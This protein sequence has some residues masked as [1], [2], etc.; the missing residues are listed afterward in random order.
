[1]RVTGT[2]SLFSSKEGCGKSGATGWQVVS[3]KGHRLHD[4]PIWLFSDLRERSS[5]E[6]GLSGQIPLQP[7]MPTGP[8]AGCP[9]PPNQRWLEPLP[10]I[11]CRRLEATSSKHTSKV[12]TGHPQRAPSSGAASPKPLRLQIPKLGPLPLTCQDKCSAW[13]WWG[14]IS[15]WPQATDLRALLPGRPQPR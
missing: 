7:L 8:L 2:S 12:G 13:S 9:V 10:T 15:R 1:M 11:S 4:T 6:P 14:T 5:L 3:G